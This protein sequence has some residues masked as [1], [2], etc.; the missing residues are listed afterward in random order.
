VLRLTLIPLIRNIQA[1]SIK[2]LYNYN[3][4]ADNVTMMVENK[5]SGS[6]EKKVCMTYECPGNS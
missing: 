3:S 6:K 1:L 5:H 2:P 4:R